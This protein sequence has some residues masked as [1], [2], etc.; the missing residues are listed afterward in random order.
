MGL[1]LVIEI[2]GLTDVHPPLLPFYLVSV[3]RETDALRLDEV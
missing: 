2:T 1:S 3:H